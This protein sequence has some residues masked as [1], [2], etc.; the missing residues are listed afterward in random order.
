MPGR[1]DFLMELRDFEPL[2]SAVRGAHAALTAPP[3][4]PWRALVS[5]APR[6]IQ[7]RP[8]LLPFPYERPE[9]GRF[10]RSRP[11]PLDRLSPPRSAV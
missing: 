9:P 7:P 2:T 4:P 6:W 10:L 3:L 5:K 8:A 1:A 11:E